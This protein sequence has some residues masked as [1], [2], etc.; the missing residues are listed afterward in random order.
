[1]LAQDIQRLHSIRSFKHFGERYTRLPQCAL[2]NL[3]H[4]R[5]VINY[6]GGNLTH[7]PNSPSHQV[8]RHAKS[9]TS[10]RF[11]SMVLIASPDPVLLTYHSG[12]LELQVEIY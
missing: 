1:M 6:Q 7:F 5:G 11:S 8:H 2:N 4:H 9:K 12:R 10:E 3:A